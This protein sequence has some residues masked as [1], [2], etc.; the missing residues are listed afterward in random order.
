MFTI[1]Q[2]WAEGYAYA[3]QTS[4][5]PSTLKGWFAHDHKDDRYHLVVGDI[6]LFLYDDREG[7]V[8][9]GQVQKVALSELAARQVLIPRG[10]WH[11]LLNVGA[12]DAIVVN[13]PTQPYDHAE[14]DRG[15]TDQRGR[16]P[17]PK[18]RDNRPARVVGRPGPVNVGFG[19]CRHPVAFL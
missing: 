6:I 2:F 3:Y 8:T 1:P 10:V 16:R 19:G 7:S 14:P 13:L 4:L 5:R 17:D 9:E 15:R 11:L 18:A 12:S